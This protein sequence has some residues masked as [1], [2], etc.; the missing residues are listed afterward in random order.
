MKSDTKIKS[1]K[2]HQHHFSNTT[3]RKQL[4]L[5]NI[6]TNDETIKFKY[7]ANRIWNII[8]HPLFM[9]VNIK[10]IYTF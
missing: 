10:S 5:E 2:I 7:D 6:N 4:Q 3:Q 1:M 9:K 8:L